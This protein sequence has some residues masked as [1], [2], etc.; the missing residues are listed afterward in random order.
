[1][2]DRGLS[3]GGLRQAPRPVWQA[4]PMWLVN[5]GGA[6]VA[7]APQPRPESSDLRH[8]S[9]SAPV[10]QVH[11]RS[12]A[13][14]AAPTAQVARPAV[15]ERRPGGLAL[16]GIGYR[17][18]DDFPRR[19]WRE[20]IGHHRP[21]V[22]PCARPSQPDRKPRRPGPPARIGVLPDRLV[23]CPRSQTSQDV[24]C[25]PFLGVAHGYTGYTCYTFS[26]GTHKPFFRTPIKAHVQ[27]HV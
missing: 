27:I 4:P 23:F 1:M 7:T 5:G 16:D 18:A 12:A 21:D 15:R 9:R 6:G 8:R 2:S 20:T 26:K 17:G 10:D 19:D 13:P 24:K 22:P 3:R 14:T 11:G 25:A